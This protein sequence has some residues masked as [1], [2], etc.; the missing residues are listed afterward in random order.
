MYV[1]IS[2]SSIRLDSSYEVA[3]ASDLDANGVQWTRP[4][5]LSWVDTNGISHRY[6]PDFYLPEYNVYLDPK[7]KGIIPLHEEKIRKV[8]EQNN[9]KLYVLTV[10][11][12]TWAAIQITMGR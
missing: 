10:D 5:P 8:V 3:V 9:V 1:T 2:G 7:H 12:L 4:K 11:Q 6:Y